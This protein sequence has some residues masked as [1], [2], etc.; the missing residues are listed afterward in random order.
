KG[1]NEKLSHSVKPYAMVGAGR[2][3]SSIWKRGDARAG[4][5]YS[6]NIF[7]LTHDGRVRQSFVPSDLFSFIKLIQLLAATLSDDGC[8]TLEERRKLQDID[9]SLRTVVHSIQKRPKQSHRKGSR[10]PATM[11]VQ[12][13][14]KPNDEKR[15]KS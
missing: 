13:V 15:S 11:P 6:F 2:L 9:H 7:R 10:C 3:A 1:G 8:F 14:P 12:P 5:R 4:F